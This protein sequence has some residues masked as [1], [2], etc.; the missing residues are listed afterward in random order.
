VGDAASRVVMSDTASHV[1]V[2]DAMLQAAITCASVRASIQD[3]H[4]EGG[5]DAVVPLFSVEVDVRA[6][7]LLM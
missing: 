1:V 3:P 4:R 7:R 2:S 6:R 5:A